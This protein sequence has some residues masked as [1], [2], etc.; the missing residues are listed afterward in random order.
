VID[1]FGGIRNIENVVSDPLMKYTSAQAAVLVDDVQAEQ[2][3]RLRDDPGF[4]NE[5]ASK[6]GELA[7]PRPCNAAGRTAWED[8]PYLQPRS[9]GYLRFTERCRVARDFHRWP[10]HDAARRE[11]QEH[12]AATSSRE[13]WK[14]YYK[15]HYGVAVTVPNIRRVA[16]KMAKDGRRPR[17]LVELLDDVERLGLG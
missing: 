12:R 15:R 2:L 10:G 3:D 5:T 11:Y 9:K 16:R 1:V 7:C 4:F 14:D 17:R 13:A 6:G 8:G